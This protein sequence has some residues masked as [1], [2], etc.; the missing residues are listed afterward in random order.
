M[1]VTGVSAP[2]AAELSRSASTHMNVYDKIHQRFGFSLPDEYRSM[3]RAGFF[4]AKKEATYLW[5]P[6]AEWLS[7]REILKFEFEEYHKP[8]FIPFAFTGASDH[9]CWWPAEHE[10]AVVLCPHDSIEASFDAPSFVGSLYRRILDYCLSF[11]LDE[12][13]EVRERLVGWGKTLMPYFP[14][15]WTETLLY[16]SQVKA[17]SW[18]RKKMSGYGVLSVDRY[19]EL[20]KR[21]LEF[22]RL[23]ENFEWMNL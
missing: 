9:W 21:D 2:V 20:V 18:R 22:P 14:S 5:V 17:D 4:D 19:D 7:P 16:L 1:G 6:E 11:E 10:S 8:G 15:R 13:K 3:E 23:Y 12:E